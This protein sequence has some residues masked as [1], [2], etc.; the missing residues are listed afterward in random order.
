MSEVQEEA[1]AWLAELLLLNHRDR[2]DRVYEDMDDSLCAGK[3]AWAEAVLL[4]VEMDKLTS[5]EILAFV[6]HARAAHKNKAITG[7]PAFFARFVAHLDKIKHPEKEGVLHGL[8]PDP[9]GGGTRPEG[10][11]L[12]LFGFD[13][14]FG[15]VP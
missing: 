14:L 12:D 4:A 3:F 13:A 7:Y 6:V 1:R 15:R 9:E 8:Y 5:S 2:M 10:E 11:Y